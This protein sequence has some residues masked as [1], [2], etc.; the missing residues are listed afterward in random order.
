MKT[1]KRAYE[2]CVKHNTN[3]L[4][5][6]QGSLCDCG[7]RR[8]QLKWLLPLP[9]FHSFSCTPDQHLLIPISPLLGLM[10]NKKM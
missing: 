3:A 9:L 5:Q 7:E 1:S 8:R 2:L 4:I 10:R 6:C